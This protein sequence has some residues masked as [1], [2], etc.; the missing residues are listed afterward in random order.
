MWL[1]AVWLKDAD[2]SEKFTAFISRNEMEAAGSSQRFLY[3][4]RTTQHYIPDNHNLTICII[5]QLDMR[6]FGIFS[7]ES[8]TG[9]SLFDVFLTVHHSIDFSKY[10]L[11]AQFF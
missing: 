11:S 3:I 7:Y 4:H 9:I 6:G 10:Q 8:E 1:H 5:Y 2:I